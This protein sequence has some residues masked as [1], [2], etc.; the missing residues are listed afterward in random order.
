M[1]LQL[2]IATKGKVGTFRKSLFSLMRDNFL[3]NLVDMEAFL[4]KGAGS[5]LYSKSMRR[6]KV[7]AKAL[8][9]EVPLGYTWDAK[10]NAKR[11][12]KQ[13]AFVAAKLEA[14]AAVAITEAEAVAAE[15]AAEAEAA[16]ATAAAAAEPVAKAALEEADAAW[17]GLGTK[18]W[19]SSMAV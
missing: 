9:T 19:S 15:V 11:R 5:E 14:A 17:G 16:V 4:T 12:A 18:R 2:N 1:H 7:W 3:S 10:A 8:G 6:I 13:D